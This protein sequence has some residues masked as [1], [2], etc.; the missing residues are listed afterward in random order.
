MPTQGYPRSVARMRLFGLP[1]ERRS[2]RLVVALSF[3]TLLLWIGGSAILPLLPTY[4]RRH[5]S[6]AAL[7]GIVMATYFA[8]SVLTQYPVGRL[9]DRI[10][11]RP[12]IL[13]GL[14]VFAVGS[15]GFALTSGPG[16]AIVFRAL[17]GVGAGAVT[18]ASAAILGTELALDERGGA[19]GA[20]YGSQMLALAIGPLL[21][22]LG[23]I[24]SMGLLFVSA[25]V[26]AGFAALPVLVSVAESRPG[27][28][29]G[30][31]AGPRD[32]RTEEL[33]ALAACAPAAVA[34][35]GSRA[36][37]RITPALVGVVLVFAA[38]GL[39]GGVYESCWTLLLQ[40]RRATTFEIGLSW[41]LFALPFAVLS[42]PAGRLAQR[43][44]RR[45]LTLG[46][47]AVSIGFC[48]LYPF[49]HSVPALLGFA[50]LEA[51]GS[52]IGS[53]AAVLVLTEHVPA[54]VQG[55]AQGAVET[56]RTAATALAAAASGALFG[57][58]PALP[59]VVVAGVVTLACAVIARS[60][61]TVPGRAVARLAPAS[62][63]GG[64]E[65]IPGAPRP[66]QPRLLAGAQ[67]PPSL[68]K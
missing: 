31:P 66:T 7:V 19:F 14:I 28:L 23:G 60:W 47:L 34:R 20:L 41:T 65:A 12:I 15:V 33:E 4:L 2:R 29:V 43:F 24:S 27:A 54:E 3:A 48:V 55:E 39:L 64:G 8:A 68:E 53:P 25:A 21:G 26:A 35:R 13:G 9:S 6:S 40:L 51:A 18:V 30:A 5:G 38:S 61:R 46:A 42:V 57:V 49:L 50:V 17:Q 22:T 36:H 59:F 45:G 16:P 32:E 10:G 67:P 37:L 62:A 63:P 56:A 44:D 52:V 58:D 1:A 11:R